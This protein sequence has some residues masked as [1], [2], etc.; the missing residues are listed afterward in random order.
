[1]HFNVQL[2]A[3]F[4]SSPV[5]IHVSSRHTPLQPGTA[6]CECTGHAKEYKRD[7]ETAGRGA[8]GAEDRRVAA[9][10]VT[11]R[12]SHGEHPEPLFL[13][14]IIEWS[15]CLLLKQPRICIWVLAC[16]GGTQSEAIAA[17]RDPSLHVEQWGMGLRLDL[18]RVEV[19]WGGFD[20]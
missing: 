19:S 8:T 7:K 5:A 16:K 10:A 13:L 20:T 14:G 15:T 1:M 11:G 4:H 18:T 9:E 3:P 6:A 2:C 17:Q 12:D